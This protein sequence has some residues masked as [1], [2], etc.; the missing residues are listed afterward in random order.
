MNKYF[1]F[2]CVCLTVALVQAQEQETTTDKRVERDVGMPDMQ[3]M[4][5]NAGGVMTDMIH[6]F[7]EGGLSINEVLKSFCE[8]NFATAVHRILC[9]N[10]RYTYNIMHGSLQRRFM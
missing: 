3:Q 8:G 2:A 1:V 9:N 5:G 10:K 6:T 7:S 4:P